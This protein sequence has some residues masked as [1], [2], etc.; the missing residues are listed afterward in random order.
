MPDDFSI[1]LNSFAFLVAQLRASGYTIYLNNIIDIL[2]TGPNGTNFTHY[3]DDSEVDSMID[4]AQTKNLTED[5][6]RAVLG[7]IFNTVV[8]YIDSDFISR[9]MIERDLYTTQ[10]LDDIVNQL[11]IADIPILTGDIQTQID[12]TEYDSKKF[13]YSGKYYRL[14]IWSISLVSTLNV[15]EAIAESDQNIPIPDEIIQTFVL[16]DVI[17]PSRVVEGDFDIVGASEDML[18]TTSVA[19]MIVANIFYNYGLL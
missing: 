10:D 17:K 7:S 3:A 11:D 1:Q 5:R 19:L 8:S 12:P 13:D 9:D 6:D 14:Y 2:N 15:A 16:N 18:K 4:K